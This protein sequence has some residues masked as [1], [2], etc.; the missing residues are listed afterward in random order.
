MKQTKNFKENGAWEV[1]RLTRQMSSQ[2][3]EQRLAESP[4]PYFGKAENDGFA[5]PQDVHHDLIIMP[6]TSI[7]P[8]KK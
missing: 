2:A 4:V 1:R 5:K 6:E 8:L 3:T 7:F